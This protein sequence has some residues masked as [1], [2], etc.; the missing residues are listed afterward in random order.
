MNLLS[1]LRNEEHIPLGGVLLEGVPPSGCVMKLNIQRQF[2]TSKV[3]S[4]IIVRYLL[5]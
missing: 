2:W 3:Q 1:V 4:Y 5:G